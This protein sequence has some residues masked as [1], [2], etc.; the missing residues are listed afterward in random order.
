MKK[1]EPTREHLWLARLVGEWTWSH[2]VEPTATTKVTRLEGT[3]SYR[4]VGPFWVVGES[5]GS[6]PDGDLH[7]SL[8]TLG[9]DPGKGRFVG[10]WI[11]SSM[12][13]LWA[14]DG[15]LD[16]AGRSLSLYS[17]GPAMDGSDAVIPYRDVM[18][19]VDDNTRTRT[20]YTKDAGG[21][22]TEFMHVEYRRR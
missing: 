9:W 12:P 19:F 22:W 16:E 4:A 18:T 15:E 3:E 6:M 5:V 10:T 13:V 1:Y 11:G 21:Q 20:A 7:V 17:D 8:T 14:Y 2:D